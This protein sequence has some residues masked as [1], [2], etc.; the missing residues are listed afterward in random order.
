MLSDTSLAQVERCLG[1]G[2]LS[3]ALAL[4]QASTTATTYF[5]SAQITQIENAITAGIASLPS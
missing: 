4:I 2:S 5:S 3:T 1:N